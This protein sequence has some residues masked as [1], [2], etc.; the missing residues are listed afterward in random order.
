M[1]GGPRA[2]AAELALP[3][4]GGAELVD[5]HRPLLAAV[6]GEVALAAP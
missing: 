2:L 1:P 6:T 5:E 3:V 4:G